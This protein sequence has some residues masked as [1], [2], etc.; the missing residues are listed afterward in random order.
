MRVPFILLILLA[1]CAPTATPLPPTPTPLPTIDVPT[2]APEPSATPTATPVPAPARPQYTMNVVLDYANKSAVVDETIVYPNH[3]GQPLTELV[4]AVEPNLWPN[5]FTLNALGLNGAPVSNYSLDTHKLTIPLPGVMQPESVATIQIQFTLALPQLEQQHGVRPQ[6]FGYSAL[7]MNLTDWYPFVVPNIN[8][9]WV[10]HDPWYDGEHLVYEAADF[11]VNVK[12]SDPAAKLIIA[13]SG[14][15]SQNGDFTSYT[16]EA[17]RT[18][19]LSISDQYQ[20]SAVQVG[21]IL[22]TS[23]YFPLY[24]GAAEMAMNVAA[25]S[26]QIFSQRY[27]PYPHKTLAVVMGD[28]NDG[29]EFSALFF[30]T[31]GAYNLFDGSYQNLTVAVSAHET[32]H[33]WWFEQVASDQ[34]LQPWLDEALAAYS[35][36]VYYET[37]H[38]ES[39]AWWWG[40]WTPRVGGTAATSWVDTDIYSAGGF[41]P[42]T[43]GIYQRGARFLDELR[44]RIGD[45]AFFAFLQD[46]LNQEKGKIATT[47]DF[48]HIL[49]THTSVDYS[50]IMRQYFQ[51]VY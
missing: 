25:Q 32:S 2:P 45:E 22:V 38:P 28:F 26:I 27:G 5:C 4:L 34:A 15:P 11:T 12:P 33:Q 49:A 7:Q 31:R 35:E 41:I 17:G 43:N 9:Q 18:F 47:S 21:D 30:M 42:Y 36:H 50:D 6:I 13:S 44:G 39:V 46:Y 23:Y 51:N 29:M 16:L 3:T 1:A 48:F 14:A 40:Y 10:L 19:A 8:G 37:T 20:T 24:K